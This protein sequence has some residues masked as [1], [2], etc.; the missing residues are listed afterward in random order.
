MSY[1]QY[2]GTKILSSFLT[3]S[4]G[5]L[6][7]GRKKLP[8][9]NSINCLGNPFWMKND[10]RNLISRSIKDRMLVTRSLPFPGAL[11][12]IQCPLDWPAYQSP[13][14]ALLKST[15]LSLP[16][17]F[18]STRRLLATWLPPN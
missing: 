15:S 3:D 9:G 16:G 10:V 4:L 17:V 6:K 8:T 5:P 18:I 2:G 14:G 11:L 7:T 12:T 13:L 1:V